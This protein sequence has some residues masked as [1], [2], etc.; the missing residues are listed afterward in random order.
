ML[1]QGK[2]NVFGPDYYGKAS[3]FRGEEAE[4]VI[5]YLNQYFR[6]LKEN[7]KKLQ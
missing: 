3:Y 6:Y 2:K 4:I 1:Q 5:R 7:T